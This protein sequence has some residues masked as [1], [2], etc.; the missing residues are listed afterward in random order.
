MGGQ[1]LGV[2]TGQYMACSPELYLK[3]HWV[4]SHASQAS[5]IA[6]GRSVALRQPSWE[7]Q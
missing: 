4:V 1:E 2:G 6:Q 3:P 7:Q 5:Q